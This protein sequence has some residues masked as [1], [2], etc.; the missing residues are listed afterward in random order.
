M[1]LEDYSFQC[2][3]IQLM[4]AAWLGLQ[5]KF[6]KVWWNMHFAE[7]FSIYYVP[8]RLGSKFPLTVSKKIA[9]VKLTSETN[10]SEH[11]CLLLFV[12][13]SSQR[14]WYILS[15]VWCHA[16]NLLQ[17]IV[18]V[19]FFYLFFLFF[20]SFLFKYIIFNSE[21]S[22]VPVANFLLQ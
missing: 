11:L 13:L 10:L 19:I 22:L 21:E 17:K 18:R 9:D 15:I 2:D 7:Y 14:S 4:W 8:L 20:F 1:S 12:C 3:D 6:H 5:S 16:N